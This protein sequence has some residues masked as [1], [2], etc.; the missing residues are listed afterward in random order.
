MQHLTNE[1]CRI[2]AVVSPVGAAPTVAHHWKVKTKSLKSQLG[3]FLWG[4]CR[5]SPFL[6]GFSGFLLHVQRHAIV[7][8]GELE[9]L[10]CP[11]M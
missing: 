1:L 8:V 5:F 2:E 7:G 10:N 3:A 4:V 6:P 11:E 9:T